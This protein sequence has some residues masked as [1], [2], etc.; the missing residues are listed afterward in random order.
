MDRHNSGHEQE[1]ITSANSSESPN[2]PTREKAY[3]TEE[4]QDWLIA[5]LSNQLGLD[6]SDIG[7]NE[8][9]AGFGVDSVGAI[10][11]SGDLE[12]WLGRQL[13]PTLLWDYPTI[14]ILSQ[15]LAYP[16]GTAGSIAGYNE[17]AEAPKEPIAIIGLG[18]RFPG[19]SNPSE[20]WK[21]LCDGVDAI[22][23]VPADRWDVDSFY[24]PNLAAIGKMNSRW[25]GFITNVDKFDAQFFGISPREAARMDPQQRIL[26]E[27]AWEALEDAGQVPAMLAGSRTGVF[28]GIGT[29]DYGRMQIGNLKTCS[30][31]YAGT[32]GAVSIAANRISYVLNFRGPSISVDTACSSSLVATHLAC[33]SLWNSEATL[34]LAGGVNLILDPKPSVT[35]SKGGFLSPDGRCR[36]F[37][38]GANGYVRGEGVGVVVLKRLGEALKDG[39]PIYGLI[40]G[41][42]INQD[43]HSNGL[44]APNQQAQELLL[45]D[46]YRRA[47]ISPG[48]VQ[49]VETHG[50]GTSL[51]DPIEVKALGTVLG[52]DRPAGQRFAIGS[53][54]TN[55]G[56]AETAA[57]IASLIKVALMLKH[58]SIPASLHFKEPNPHIP[59]DT[60]PLY[61]QESLSSWP[62]DRGPALA[63]VSGF[64]FGGTN[65]HL[66][67]SEA[68]AANGNRCGKQHESGRAHL[69]TL[70]ARS[71]EALRALASDYLELADGSTQLQLEDVCYASSIRRGHYDH[72]LA[73]VASSW[74][75]VQDRLEAFLK[76]E[77]RSGMSSRRRVPG[78]RPKLSFVF[79]GQGSQRWDMGRLLMEQ[80]PVFRMKVEQCDELFRGYSGWSVIEQLRSD[81]T[82]SRIDETEVT[83]PAIFI[84]Q[85][86]LASLLSSW[87]IIPDAVVGHSMGEIAAAH[88]SGALTLED[89]VCAIFHRGRLM[90]L[91]AGQGGTAALG[92]SLDEAKEILA[93]HLDRV[94]I[95]A[96]NS[97]KSTVI[98][99]DPEAL[100]EVLDLLKK[101]DVFCQQ[102]RVNHAFHSPQMDRLLPELEQSLKGIQ[103]GPN[104]IPYFSTVTSGLMDGRNLTPAYWSRNLREPV[105]FSDTIGVMLEDGYEVFLELS[106]HPVL[107]GAISRCISDKGF[108]GTA[109]SSLR[110]EEDERAM[111]LGALGAI[112]TTGYAVN[113][114]AIYEEGHRCVQLPHYPFQRERFW[115]E[116][117]DLL[118]DS[119]LE[120]ALA[121]RHPLLGRHLEAAQHRGTH[122]WESDL[123]SRLLPFLVDH[124]LQGVSLL[125]GTAYVEMALAASTEGFEGSPFALTEIELKK[126]LFLSEAG[127]HTIQT[128]FYPGAA[129]QAH[130][131]IY[132]C[133]KGDATQVSWTLHA[134]GQACSEKDRE[135]SV[136]AALSSPD[137]I[138]ARCTGEISGTDYYNALQSR[139]FDYGPAFQGIERIWY[140]QGEALGQVRVPQSLEADLRRY[141]LHPAI[142]DACMH[143][144]G[145]V[146]NPLA[147]DGAGGLYIPVGFD[148]IRVFEPTGQQFW[149]HAKLREETNVD[150]NILHGDVRLLDDTGRVMAEALG[151]RCTRLGE[152]AGREAEK[153]I[154]DSLYEIQWQPMPRSNE[155]TVEF[156]SEPGVWLIFSDHAG[157]G[158]KLKNLLEDRGDSCVMV[159]PGDGFE[160]LSRWEFKVCPRLAEDF[161]ELV[162]NLSDFDHQAYRGIVHLWNLDVAPPEEKTGN[163][164]EPS[165][166]LGCI[167]LL[168][169]VQ[170][171]GESR[172]SKSNGFWIVS[173]GA[174]D[175]GT[176]LTPASVFQ[177]AGYGLG[178][179]IAFEAPHLG[180][181]R[182]DI[183]PQGN[184]DDLQQLLHELLLPESESQ[185]A[186]R[187]LERYVP[188]LTRYS[189]AIAE[190]DSSLSSDNANRL[191]LPDTEAFSLEISPPY[192][193]DNLELRPSIRRKPGRG[194]VE[195]Q[196]LAAGLNF[197]DVLKAMGLYPGIINSEVRLGDEC[198]GRIV[199]VGDDVEEYKV[200]DEVIA[201][202]NN[203]FSSFVTVDLHFVVPKP[204]NISFE[205]AATMPVAFSTAYYSLCHIGRLNKGERVLIHA[206]AGGVGLA[207]VSLAQSVGAEVFATAG[208]HEKREYLRSLGVQHVMDSRSMDWAQEVM[209]LTNNEGV[210]MVLNSLAGGAIQA[211]LATLRAFGRFV[212][213]GKIDIYENNQLGLY[214]FRNNVAF[215]AIDMEQVLLHRPDLSQSMLREMVRRLQFG[216]LNPLPHKTFSIKDSAGAFRYMAQRKN[217]GKIVI[218]FEH[219]SDHDSYG[220]IL[221]DCTYLIT[222]GLGGLG[223]KVAQ[224]LVRSGAQNL[225]LVGRNSPSAEASEALGSMREAGATIMIGQVDVAEADQLAAFMSDVAMKL[226]PVRGV[227]HA[228][229]VLDDGIL[230]QLD[231][232]RFYK[233]LRPK[234]AGAWNLHAQTSGMNLDFFMLFSSAATIFSNPGQGNYVAANAFLDALAHYRRAK[235]LPALSINWGPW[236]EVGMASHLNQERL[237]ARGM[238]SITPEKG[239]HAFE[240]L[241]DHPSPQIAV[242][243]INWAKWARLSSA[244]TISS[245]LSLMI[246]SDGATQSTAGETPGTGHINRN[247]ILNADASERT[248]LLE[249]YLR[250]AGGRVLGL[251]A[252]K[253]DVQ[254]PLNRLGVDSLMAVELKNRIEADLAVDVPVLKVIE[255]ASLRELASFLLDRLVPRREEL[256]T[257]S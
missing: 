76:G 86:G 209:R 22:T 143:V 117:E 77:P 169:L 27:V 87:G 155:E 112:H 246:D 254:Q 65:A 21:L 18:C 208:S 142:L 61:V 122:F 200:G 47:G 107:V 13:P 133:P 71:P 3:R 204:S 194:E 163:A 110:R 111:M 189:S 124:K 64:G 113:W 180:C 211:G 248:Q 171:L 108:D 227:V 159:S 235:G 80:E 197:R 179:V 24:D 53:V 29:I 216:E 161:R 92:L 240:M 43:G 144:L 83:Q 255:G 173:R 100:D 70:S 25:G 205:E 28:I 203:G 221:S 59:F 45:R 128:I 192:V 46:A 94:S 182:I 228:A 164:W 5:K 238:G 115:L 32:G 226:P 20:F 137:E 165:I 183:D 188:R 214:P 245:L 220:H 215:S 52:I 219:A 131:R 41:S 69:M 104:S 54:K 82:S 149:S 57:G 166:E 90:Q 257:I 218:S 55:I 253:I 201:I 7:I 151:V 51:G 4:I 185:V 177:S 15:H 30:N 103:P 135:L 247:S 33:Q 109:L 222:G 34:A 213:I 101:R 132:S 1:E 93:G 44:T 223:L 191:E 195:I 136:S 229:G 224:Y 181:T 162:E 121:G 145:A 167:S 84:L 175:I 141:Q 72:R 119:S 230:L 125:P 239:V 206:A 233:V 127:T 62:E 170:A 232:D 118:A 23:E 139:G 17:S 241:I 148:Q 88:V 249:E 168:H 234:I 60:L 217:T 106:P 146:T 9:F 114:G 187:N 85:V 68:P 186:F 237:E 38:A 225:A 152:A 48:D 40:R 36:A 160:R 126:A 193:L 116:M 102:L 97:P 66:V 19:A 6:S 210:D 138:R 178:G 250:D 252:S 202:A 196:V 154:R 63:G 242:M 99:G 8:A 50:T 156:E 231:R 79:S 11:I 256:P 10:S 123:S 2:A 172:W 134:T 42:S 176:N 120:N 140:Q 39:D 75:D 73:L 98:S 56:H 251:A 37:D 130:F 207:A 129:G 74:E 153:S 174:Q 105:L 212:E 49:Y 16:A 89:A 67:L 190:S 244:S 91:T 26:L 58:R 95:A 147:A 199:G 14:Q 184:T 236:T 198:T 150:P 243:P 157:V 158:A 35:L 31:A 78:R 96:H 81:E 12:V